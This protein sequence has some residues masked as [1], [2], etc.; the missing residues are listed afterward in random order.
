MDLIGVDEIATELATTVDARMMASL[1][2][3]ISTLVSAP[4]VGFGAG[5]ARMLYDA[6][7]G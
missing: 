4:R 5:P 6:S 3:G 7:F 2:P 1:A